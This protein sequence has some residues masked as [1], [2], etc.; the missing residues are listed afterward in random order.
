[1]EARVDDDGPR[2]RWLTWLD[3]VLTTEFVWLVLGFAVLVVLAG[4]WQICAA[5]INFCRHR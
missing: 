2:Y 3:L 4:T 1:M 5:A